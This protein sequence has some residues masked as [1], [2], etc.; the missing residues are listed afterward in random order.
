[1]QGVVG[2][3]YDITERKLAENAL[4]LHSEIMQNMAESVYL[5]RASD[6]VIV[7]T[8]PAF[9]RLFGYGA[10]EMIGKFVSIVNAPTGNS[11][12][13]TAREII[14]TLDRSGVWSGETLNIKKDGTR[15]W[16]YANVSRFVHDEHGEVW[17]SYH[18]DITERK[19]AEEALR[20][21]E[22]RYRHLYTA[23]PAM[24]YSINRE[25]RIVNVSDRWLEVLGYER[26]E[27]IGRKSVEFLTEESR[28]YAEEVALPNF[29]KRGAAREVQYQF[30]RKDGEIVDVLL[31]ESLQNLGSAYGHHRAKGGGTGAAGERGTLSR[32]IR[33][34]TS[35]VT[36]G[37]R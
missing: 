16:C 7:Y 34:I 32:L 6:G 24:L 37:R 33:Q 26:S 2:L 31:R 8:N 20:A 17:V 10:G 35:S 22:E 4:R 36:F 28:R 23:T 30:V 12:E 11:P 25:G 5:I 15:F 29:W 19:E 9:E 14:A 18:I 1:V 21:S 27:V 3:A 13:D